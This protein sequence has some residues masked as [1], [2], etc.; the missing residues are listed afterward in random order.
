MRRFTDSHEPIDK[1]F[2][3]LFRLALSILEIVFPD[4][5]QEHQADIVRGITRLEI[6]PFLQELLELFIAQGFQELLD[7]DVRIPRF[8]ESCS[9]FA[10]CTRAQ[11]ILEPELGTLDLL[12][13]FDRVFLRADPV[14][15]KCLE[16]PLFV[17]PFEAS[18]VLPAL[19]LFRGH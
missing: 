9:D 7:G 8:S 6:L 13:P 19:L 14:T 16:I 17:C 2:V 3:D 5:M 11:L 10:G 12:L 15:G 1:I 4:P 18:L